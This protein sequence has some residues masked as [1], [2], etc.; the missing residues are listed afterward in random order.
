MPD[1]SKPFRFLDLPPE[2]RIQVYEYASE[3]RL[4]YSKVIELFT[5]APLLAPSILKL[6]LACHQVHHE[7]SELCR[8]ATVD[9]YQRHDFEIDIPMEDIHPE[10]DNS[11]MPAKLH[12]LLKKA[13]LTPAFPLRCLRLHCKDEFDYTL[14]LYAGR[15]G[16]IVQFQSWSGGAGDAGWEDFWK[17]AGM[18]RA[19][20]MYYG[21]RI[22]DVKACLGIFL[23]KCGWPLHRTESIMYPDRRMRE[24]AQALVR[25]RDHEYVKKLAR[26]V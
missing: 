15:A 12:H 26:N 22:V 16:V 4:R 20:L 17:R 10:S 9:F 7:T 18:R 24:D 19:C 23:K 25:C 5:Q 13:A 21:M 11:P 3:D 6:T 2:I 8:E 1:Q 14:N